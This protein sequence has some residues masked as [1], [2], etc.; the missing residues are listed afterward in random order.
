MS[1]PTHLPP[2]KPVGAV[3]APPRSS[4]RVQFDDRGQAVWEWAVQTGMFDRNAD[5]QRV[6]AL[7]ESSMKLELDEAPAAAKPS[8][9]VAAPRRGDALTPYDRPAAK[10]VPAP[11][12]PA[13]TSPAPRRKDSQGSDPY[14][15][16]PAKRPEAMT[17]NPYDRTPSRGR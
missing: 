6:R 2:P 15:Q 7:S 8:T 1:K 4:G 12:T 5:T 9:V 14:S 16:G 11:P 10:P 13:R 17:F 3:K